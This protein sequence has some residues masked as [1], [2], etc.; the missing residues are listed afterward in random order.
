MKRKW[1]CYSLGWRESAIHSLTFQCDLW[2]AISSSNAKSNRTTD[3]GRQR[4]YNTFSSLSL[5]HFRPC[6]FLSTVRTATVLRFSHILLC[7]ITECVLSHSVMYDIRCSVCIAVLSLHTEERNHE[8][9]LYM[10]LLYMCLLCMILLNLRLLYMSL[11][12]MCLLCM[13]LLYLDE[14]SISRRDFYISYRVW[15]DP[16]YTMQCMYRI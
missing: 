2:T 4:M 11:L 3:S 14:T 8:R 7:M 15:P 12:Y 9:L 13:S 1:N 6:W 16:R 5:S 10:S